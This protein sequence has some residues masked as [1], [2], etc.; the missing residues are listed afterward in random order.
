MKYQ[1]AVGFIVLA[2]IL[3]G[4][5]WLAFAHTAVAPSGPKE[6]GTLS[7]DAKYYTVKAAYPTETALTATAGVAAD[8]AAVA[9]MKQFE[10]DTIAQFK[11]DGNFANLTPEDI[12]MMGLDQGR[13]YALEMEY[14]TTTAPHSVS[15]VFTI[16]EDTLGAH[17][18]GYFHTFT[19]DSTTGA[20]LALGDLFTSGADYLHKLSNISRAELPAVIGTDADTSYIASGT[21]P[22]EANFGNFALDKD[23]LVLIFPPY[24][25]GPYALGPETL[26]IPRTELKDILKPEYQ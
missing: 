21:T 8:A 13:Q 18:N 6:S 9:A 17:P 7:E 10:L 16:Y 22:D 12:S 26:Y 24:Q 25:V 14:S 20:N 4:I 2:L 11:T 15:Y 23:N 1:N 3:G 19:F 5:V